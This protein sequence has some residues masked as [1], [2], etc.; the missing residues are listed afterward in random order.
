MIKILWSLIVSSLML[1]AG[2]RYSEPKPSFDAP[3]QI[4][5]KLNMSDVKEVNHML[6]TIYNLLKDYPSDTLKVEV[7]AYGPG[8]RTLKKDYDK[9]TLSRIRS[10]MEY[11]V[12]FIGC[13]NTM[14]T[15]KWTEKDFIDNVTYVQAGIA[16]VI[17]RQIGGWIN[18]T[19]Y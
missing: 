17:E 8:M 4:I 12:D 5:M 2:M 13:R 7:I 18:A 11:E 3:P 10:L 1:T 9:H 19:P 16:Q 14:E 6:G 15:M